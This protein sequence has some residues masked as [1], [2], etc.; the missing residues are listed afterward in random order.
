MRTICHIFL[1]I[2]IITL[3]NTCKSDGN[4]VVVG[5]C[6]DEVE[7]EQSYKFMMLFKKRVKELGGRVIVKSSNN[8]HEQQV[9]QVNALID[10]G[11]T[12]LVIRPVEP[13]AATYIVDLAKTN[14]IKVIAYDK[15]IPNCDLSCFISYDYRRIGQI[16]SESMLELMPKGNYAII[17]GNISFRN[18]FLLHEGQRSILKK[19]IKHNE[20]R[21]LVDTSTR[22]NDYESGYKSAKVLLNKFRDSVN[23]IIT[24]SD[25]LAG[26]V[27]R[28][29]Q[30][31][32]G[33]NGLSLAEKTFVSG[34]DAET[35]AL[36]RVE[37]GLQTSTIYK[38]I[39]TSAITCARIAMEI[40]LKHVVKEQKTEYINNGKTKV[41]TILLP[42]MVI[43]Q[44]N[45]S[46]VSSD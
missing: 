20:I 14:G 9:K 23:V 42:S 18:N 22:G 33:S 8:N 37:T 43:N 10:N 40:G 25:A 5:L 32:V 4:A 29:L 45:R 19:S 30:E 31:A 34:V 46:V 6:M 1:F 36:R 13:K 21:L 26:G 28:A 27:I 15:L 41:P 44:Y 12:V 11:M 7:L 24:S 38:P 35:I 3:F 17:D 39:K 16:Q 2:F